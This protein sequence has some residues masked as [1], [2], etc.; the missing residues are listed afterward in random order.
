MNTLTLQKRAVPA[1]RICAL[2]LLALGGCSDF[3]DPEDLP[4][5][6]RDPQLSALA[7]EEVVRDGFSFRIPPGFSKIDAIPIDSDA[8]SY[9]RGEDGVHYDYGAYSGPWQATS[10][11]PVSGVTKAL[12]ML[13]GRPAQ[14]VSYRLD[15][16]YVV[17]AWWGDVGR[18]ALGSLDLVVRGES[19][20]P[21]GRRE[22]LAVIHSVR[23]D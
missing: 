18:S 14:L 10:N 19:D 7:W 23:F 13:G 21:R 4:G 6:L 2:L 20:T 16:R 11:E 17:R 15:G 8:A 22:L 9:T 3:L 5:E 12:V 1:R